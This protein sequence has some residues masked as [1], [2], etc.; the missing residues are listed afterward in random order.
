MDSP[1]LSSKVIGFLP[2]ATDEQLDQI[3]SMVEL[4]RC[5]R[6]N[7]SDRA[8]GFHTAHFEL[9]SRPIHSADCSHV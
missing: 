4:E 1:C 8:L 2:Y 9:R 6:R 7:R 5:L 3:A